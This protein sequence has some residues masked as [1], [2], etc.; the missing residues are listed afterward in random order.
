[1]GTPATCL[2]RK[3]RILF[4]DSGKRKQALRELLRYGNTPHEPEPE[5]VRLAILKLSGGDLDELKATVEGAKEDWRDVVSWAER[6]RQTRLQLGNHKLHVHE[7]QRIEQEDR[8]E[9]TQWLT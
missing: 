9:W 1:M 6:P 5:R 8:N 3:L 4:P 2:V 7:S